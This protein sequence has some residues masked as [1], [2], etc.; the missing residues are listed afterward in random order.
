MV[1]HEQIGGGLQSC[2]GFC[3]RPPTACL[4][5]IL[6]VHQGGTHKVFSQICKWGPHTTEGIS[7]QQKG[8]SE[9]WKGVRDLAECEQ[10]HSLINFTSSLNECEGRGVTG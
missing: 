2:P 8:A 9:E 3:D 5:D 6:D 7:P 1:E 4:K 10:L